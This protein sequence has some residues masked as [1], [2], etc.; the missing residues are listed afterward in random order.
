M[1]REELIPKLKAI[2]ADP[3]GVDAAEARATLAAFFPLSEELGNQHQSLQYEFAQAR[4]AFV[5][6]EPGAACNETFS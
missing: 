2:A 1:T 4:A 6:G 3:L 5:R